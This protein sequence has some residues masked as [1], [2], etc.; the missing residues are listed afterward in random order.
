MSADA[1]I[2]AI[3]NQ[4]KAQ[5]DAGNVTLNQLSDIHHLATDTNRLTSVL[6]WL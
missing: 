5:Y 3:A 1:V 6:K 2:A 4:L